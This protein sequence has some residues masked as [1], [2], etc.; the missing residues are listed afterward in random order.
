MPARDRPRSSEFRRLPGLVRW[1]NRQARL[2]PAHQA[3]TLLTRARYQRLTGDWNG[4]I[5]TLNKSIAAAEAF[6][7]RF[8]LAR[9][10][11]EMADCLREKNDPAAADYAAKAEEGFAACGAPPVH[12]AAAIDRMASITS[13]GSSS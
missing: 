11:H 8:W 10:H 4:A 9:A 13:S 12:A 3:P 7:A 6:S 1:A 5:A 2:Y